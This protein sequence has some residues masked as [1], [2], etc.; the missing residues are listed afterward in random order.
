MIRR[1]NYR[2]MF[3]RSVQPTSCAF[4][5]KSEHIAATVC[6]SAEVVKM[7]RR[8][9]SGRN[10]HHQRDSGPTHRQVR[11]CVRRAT[12]LFHRSMARRRISHRCA[13]HF[14]GAEDWPT[15][16]L[17]ANEFLLDVLLGLNDIFRLAEVTPVVTISAKCLDFFSLRGAR[18]PVRRTV[19]G[20]A[21]AVGSAAAARAAITSAGPVLAP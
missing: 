10:R 16:E 2:A 19:E 20:E 13:S 18:R 21:S 14:S 8:T 17:Q 1:E 5:S 3:R 6:R 12:R 7:S 11:E 4:F 15:A 9:L